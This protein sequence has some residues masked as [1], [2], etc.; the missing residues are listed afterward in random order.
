MNLI[1]T[2]YAVSNVF[3]GVQELDS[4]GNEKVPSCVCVLFMNCSLVLSCS[5]SQ[6]V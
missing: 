1:L 2:G 3:N 6:N 4:G 5:I